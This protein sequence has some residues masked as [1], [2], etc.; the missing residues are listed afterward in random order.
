ML[1]GKRHLNSKAWMDQKDKPH[2][3]VNGEEDKSSEKPLLGHRHSTGWK[4]SPSGSMAVTNSAHEEACQLRTQA[5][6]SIGEAKSESLTTR[7]GNFNT[8]FS[9]WIETEAL[10]SAAP[11]SHLTERESALPHRNIIF[12][13]GVCGVFSR[14]NCGLVHKR[15]VDKCKSTEVDK[16]IFQL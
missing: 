7:A 15:S 3:P 8:P 14:L 4:L 13:W 10:N 6:N 9:V 1:Y 11:W 12:F 2:T 5:P 16:V